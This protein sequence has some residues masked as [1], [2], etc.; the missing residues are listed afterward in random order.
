MNASA[1][2]NMSSAGMEYA[3]CLEEADLSYFACPDLS[4]CNT[5]QSDGNVGLAFGLTIGAGLAT[6]LGALLPF[7]P[8]IKRSNT[9]FL[10][11]G[12]GL[13]A[14]VMLYVS[15]TEIWK[16][17]RDNFC[18]VTPD[19]FDLAV[20]ACFF[21]GI[22]LTV[23]L[24]LIV[25]G[26]QK[27]DCG[28]C[29]VRLRAR[30]RCCL[31]RQEEQVRSITASNGSIPLD[32]LDLRKDMT[33]SLG[34]GSIDQS[35]TSEQQLHSSTDTGSRQCV[36]ITP[37]CASVSVASVAPS[38]NTINYGIVSVNELFSNSS[39]LRMNA[40]IPE[41]AAEEVE[42]EEKKEGEGL[43]TDSASSHVNVQVEQQV[44]NGVIRR[45]RPSYEEMVSLLLPPVAKLII[46]DS[47]EQGIVLVLYGRSP[48]P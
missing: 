8:C 41:S 12:L 32:K 14:G 43:T 21:G 3:M 48:R 24:D 6:T 4:L 20:T 37:D 27:I 42:R 22:L 23:L 38:D 15:F 44:G 5:S 46:A 33:S 35:Q 2:T 1:C 36:A 40:V 26:L 7:V 34:N 11:I 30:K 25:D 10:A 9:Q 18:C 17:S 19:H 28:C 31:G 16:K 29:N 45:R 13:A 47:A 39:L